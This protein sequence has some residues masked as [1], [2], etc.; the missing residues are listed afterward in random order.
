MLA[1]GLPCLEG[2]RP[3]PAILKGHLHRHQR[4]RMFFN[5]PCLDAARA[6]DFLHLRCLCG[7]CRDE[8]SDKQA[9]V[10]E[11]TFH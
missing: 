3:Y 10:S 7:M 2:H 5:Q 11:N 4:Q 6:Y 8:C 9:T 1:R